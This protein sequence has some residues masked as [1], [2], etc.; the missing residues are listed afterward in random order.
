[1]LEG[2]TDPLIEYMSTIPVYLAGDKTTNP[3]MAINIS[4][5]TP[6]NNDAAYYIG[7]DNYFLTRK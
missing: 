7:D 4:P 5:L 3:F 2:Y 1:M 6:T